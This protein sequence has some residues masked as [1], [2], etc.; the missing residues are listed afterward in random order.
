MV[1]ATRDGRYFSF[2]KKYNAKKGSAV[3]YKGNRSSAAEAEPI[4]FTGTWQV[5]AN[6]EHGS[7]ELSMGSLQEG[8]Q[9]RHVA[10]G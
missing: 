9:H 10:A 2:Y 8:K 7:F 4:S 3:V 6:R 5:V 1:P